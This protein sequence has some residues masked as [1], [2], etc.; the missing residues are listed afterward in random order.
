MNIGKITGLT[1]AALLASAAAYAQTGGSGGTQMQQPGGGAQM[2]QPGGG[3]QMQQPGGKQTQQRGQSGQRGDRGAGGGV[4]GSEKGMTQERQG[5]PGGMQK[6]DQRKGAAEQR[7]REGQG[8]GQAREGKGGREKAGAGGG[9][10]ARPQLSTEERTRIRTVLRGGPRVSNVNVAI[11]VGS[12]LPRTVT[13]RPLPVSVINIV[14]QYRGYSYVLVGDT[15]L[16]V[17][18]RTFRIVAVLEA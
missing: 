3:A 13:V 2:Q 5:Q 11:R 9:V 6:G 1:V 12:Q 10:G 16:I 4:Q 14:P 7:F 17:D 18:P 8:T 15:I